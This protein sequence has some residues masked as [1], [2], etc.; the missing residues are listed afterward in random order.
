MTG[1]GPARI[2]II[3]PARN[4]ERAIG[5]TLE[6][7][8]EPGVLEVIVVDGGSED[9]T[10]EVAGG[11]AD[12]VIRTT[13]SRARQMNAGAEIA[14]GEIL[15]FLH[16]DTL[17]P[18]G[19]AAAIVQACEQTGAIGGRFDVELDAP[20]WGY[21]IVEEGINLRS[22]WSRLFT[23]DQGLFIGREVFVR[24][25]G[26]PDQPLFEDLALA[27]AMKK[28]GRVAA[29]RVRLRTSARRW[30]RSGLA[31]TVLLMWWLRALYFL[32]VSPGRLARVYR[33]V[34]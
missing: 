23:G 1:A 22:R 15:L 16:A 31:R 3:V 13:P 29:L 12:R 18:P 30:Q 8:R 10:A 20:G 33:E 24:L 28:A 7:L 5:A 4:E 19:F 17:A 11:L 9:R 34:R 2:S 6:R 26:F 27:M 25:G 21:R 14:R 32:G